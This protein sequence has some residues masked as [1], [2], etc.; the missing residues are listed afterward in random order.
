[1]TVVNSATNSVRP[2]ALF[3]RV[4]ISFAAGYFLSYL[5]RTVNAV[6]SPDLVKALNLDAADLGFLTS[7]Y[8]ISFA[9]MQLPLGILLDR[10]G[11][12]RVE[13]V[14]LL[15]AAAGAAVFAL[16]DGMSGL[17]WGRAL[18]GFGVSACLMASYK[19]LI[20]WF[21]PER[22]PLYSGMILACGGL[23]ALSATAPVEAALKLTDWRGVFFILA[24]LTLLAAAIL[25]FLVPEKHSDR[26]PERLATQLAA[27]KEIF[28]DHFF[29][30]VVPF[31][32]ASQAAFMA[33]QTLWAGPWLRDVA[34]LD[35]AAVAEHLFAT[36]A[37]MALGFVSMGFVAAQLAKRGV[38]LFVVSTSSMLIFAG[39]HVPLVM[40]WTNWAYVVWIAY[41]F[42]GTASTINYSVLA[43]SFP[44][45]LAGR[46]NTSFNL[47]A[48]LSTFCAQW[49]MG[50]V[51]NLW[52]ASDGRYAFVS[53][54]AAFGLM[55]ALQVAGFA[56]LVISRKKAAT[57]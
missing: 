45:H 2:T 15:I 32:A 43:Q 54:Q 24:G 30:R 50:L 44:L 18:I 46:V 56:W 1:L 25:F 27:L 33:I 28:T 5:F 8:F 31:S 21:P 38:P 53:Y 35:R 17:T 37:A 41:G 11:P 42:F 10:F 4:F 52:P 23:G 12:R 36:A 14:L 40:G 47:I 57:A 16:A 20:L 48:F 55:L 51:I 39:L 13:A 34:G 49:G 9:A 6:I 29:W 19:A 22:L 26:P 3:P 7:T